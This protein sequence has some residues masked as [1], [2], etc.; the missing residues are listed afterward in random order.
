MIEYSDVY[1]NYPHVEKWFPQKWM[2]SEIEKN[3]HLLIKQ[4]ILDDKQSFK[5]LDNLEDCLELVNEEMSKHKTHFRTLQ[6]TDQF[7][8]T[9]A[10]LK[11]GRFFKNMGFNIEFEPSLKNGKKADLK[12]VLNDEELYI[13]VS[14]R[15]G[16]PKGEVV[17][18]NPFEITTIKKRE[19]IA[20]KDKILEEGEQLFKNKPGI[21]ALYLHPSS[22]P[23]KRN[24]IRAF[25]FDFVWDKEKGIIEYGERHETPMISALLIIIDHADDFTLC[26]NPKAANPLPSG[27]IKKLGENNVEIID[28]EIII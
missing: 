19:P 25:G 7:N 13:E 10:E 8:S 3:K 11:V 26:L 28:P 6:N 14:T 12:T 5:F 15:K 4:L 27:I 16:I 24:V 17:E 9:F 18:N 20:F 2:E 21:V 23:E 1:E 22:A